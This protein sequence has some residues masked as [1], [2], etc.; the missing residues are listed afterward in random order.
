MKRRHG[1]DEFPDVIDKIRCGEY[2]VRAPTDKK[3][4]TSEITWTTMRLIFDEENNQVPDFFYCSKC[5]KIFNLSLRNSGQSLK[6]HVEKTCKPIADGGIDEFFMREFQPAKKKKIS[7]DDKMMVR[8]AAVE[9]IIKDM[10]PISSFNGDGMSALLSKM[11]YIGNK[12]GHITEEAMKTT[13][14]IPSRQTVSAFFTAIGKLL[15]VLSF[16][17]NFSFLPDVALCEQTCRNRSR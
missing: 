9:Y 8:N 5:H 16:H 4:Y 11:T 7:H 15:P 3:K 13:K 14:L 12:Y 17:L 2:T 6:R 10:R 1:L